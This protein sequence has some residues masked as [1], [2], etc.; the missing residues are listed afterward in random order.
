MIQVY[1]T[2]SPEA[3][4]RMWQLQQAAYRVEAELIGWA[5]LPP[6][7]ETARELMDSDET[8]IA[9]M[10][11]GELAGALSYKKNQRPARSLQNDRGP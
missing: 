4:E 6:L 9:Y 2:S 10:E 11:E 3:A 1:P 8:F 5:D 7:R